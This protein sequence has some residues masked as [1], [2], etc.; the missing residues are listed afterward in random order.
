MT[1]A[2][3]VVSIIGAG[4]ITNTVVSS[5]V[6]P[7][8]SSPSSDTSLSPPGLPVLLAVTVTLLIN[9]PASTTAW[10]ITNVAP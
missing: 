1:V 9:P 7:S 2:V 8:V 6:L 5:V 3:F 10:V 4:F